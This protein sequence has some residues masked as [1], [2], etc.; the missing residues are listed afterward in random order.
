VLAEGLAE[1]LS[2]AELEHLGADERDEHGHLRLA[3]LD[4]GGVIKDRLR[5]R[6]HALGLDVTVV[7]KDIGYELR[8]A[9]PIPFDM[10]YTRDLGY[11]AAQ[12]LLDGGSGAMVTLQEGVFKP[13]SFASMLDPTT[14]RTRVRPVNVASEQYVIARRYMV[15]LGRQDFADPASLER[16]ASTVKMPAEQFRAQ[17]AYLADSEPAPLRLATPV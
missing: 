2:P 17:F 9:E 6:L 12:F 8:C 15:R 3:E 4:I 16:L 13:V 7:L 1:R 11:C 5:E 10:E 14:G